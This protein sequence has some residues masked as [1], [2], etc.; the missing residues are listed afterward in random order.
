MANKHQNSSQNKATKNLNQTARQAV[1]QPSSQNTRQAS[2]H[3]RSISRLARRIKKAK[4]KLVLSLAFVVALPLIALG[5]FFGTGLNQEFG[6]SADPATEVRAD[7]FHTID[8][9]GTKQID[10]E[11]H[12]AVYCNGLN[13]SSASDYFDIVDGELIYKQDA[14]A[15][16]NTKNVNYCGVY[17]L[18]GH[19]NNRDYTDPEPI[20][21]T[22]SAI[23]LIIRQGQTELKG[24]CGVYQSSN[25]IICM[26]SNSVA[27]IVKT[28]SEL[29]LKPFKDGTVEI[30]LRFLRD[31]NQE[32]RIMKFEVYIEP[33]PGC[34]S[35]FASNYNGNAI[36]PKE[37]EED[38]VC[39][40]P[41]NVNHIK[42]EE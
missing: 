1:D 41:L 32:L 4:P 33:V 28:P 34:R 39:E 12:S 26:Y 11:E 6:A 27:E 40:I 18:I 8:D 23:Q 37:G 29:S 3:Q 9:N 25:Q 42:L 22:T 30:F 5:V 19:P 7:N 14:P 13:K 2:G 16:P 20:D 17:G 10:F 24:N 36:P 35:P 31:G 15:T 21:E 38:V